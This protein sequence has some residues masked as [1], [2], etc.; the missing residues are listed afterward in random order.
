MMADATPNTVDK[1][2]DVVVGG[3]EKS[4]IM[5]ER[6]HRYAIKRMSGRLLPLHDYGNVSRTPEADQNN[7]DVVQMDASLYS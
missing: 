6:L 5:M 1:Q 3:F 7:M 2:T 4:E